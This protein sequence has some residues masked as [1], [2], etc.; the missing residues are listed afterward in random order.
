MHIVLVQL[1]LRFVLLEQPKRDH[2][3]P[4]VPGGLVALIGQALRS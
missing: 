2:L 1:S 3:H 4:G